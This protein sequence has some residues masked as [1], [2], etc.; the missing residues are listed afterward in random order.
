MNPPIYRQLVAELGINPFTPLEHYQA[1]G[2]LR[3]LVIDINGRM[4]E[5]PTGWRSWFTGPHS[6]L[7]SLWHGRSATGKTFW[8]GT[9]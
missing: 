7:G 8:K 3:D 6:A 1:Y 2:I 5:T 9:R 4:T